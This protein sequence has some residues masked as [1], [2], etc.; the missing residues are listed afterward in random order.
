MVKPTAR[1]VTFPHSSAT[2]DTSPRDLLM[3]W[4]CLPLVL[5][6]SIPALAADKPDAS[7]EFFK[8]TGPVPVFKIDVDKATADS[9]RREPRKYVKCT[10]KV[11]DETFKD[12]AIHLK[13]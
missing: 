5:F 10:L 7:A 11:G 12:V 13:G 1:G 3:R 2:L 9:L 8:S 4:I 6:L